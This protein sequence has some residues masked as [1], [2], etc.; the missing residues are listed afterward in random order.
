[1][2]AQLQSDCPILSAIIDSL[3]DENSFENKKYCIK[4]NVLYRKKIVL[5]NKV[6]FRLCLPNFICE[7]ILR[8]H[9]NA[10]NNHFNTQQ[11]CLY[12]NSCFYSPGVDK[13]AQSI[14]KSCLVCNLCKGSYK[15][16]YAGKNRTFEDNLV[17]GSVL[18]L[19]IGYMPVDTVTKDKYVSIFCDRLTG[20]TSAI[21]LTSLTSKSVAQSLATYL[22]MF[23]APT[24]CQ[25]DGG[26]E[27]SGE[28]EKLCGEY[29]IM[30]KTGIPRH[31]Q[32]NGTAEVSIKNL[33]N[34][35]TRACAGSG[36]GS[37]NWTKILPLALNSLNSQCPYAL[38]SSRKQLQLSPFFNSLLPMV[39][40][41]QSGV[42]ILHKKGKP[43]PNANF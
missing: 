9:H 20:Y 29:N 40:V 22:N 2:L 17:P 1:M 43:F 7:S 36:G 18:C 26:G 30:V 37:K 13:I 6:H 24:V 33:K 35:L 34:I 12:Y 19:D 15:C 10:Q 23:P 21:P 16:Q 8:N 5:G 28:F 42:N 32:T 41:P 11:T 25:V 27:Y 39:F 31:S 4:N 14:I 38:G 3:Q